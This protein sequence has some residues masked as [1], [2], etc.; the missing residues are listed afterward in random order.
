MKYLFITGM[1][2]SGTT[3][4]SHLLSSVPDATVRHEYIPHQEGV[5]RR[6][7]VIASW[8]LGSAYAVPYLQR[9]RKD[10]ERAFSTEWFVDVDASLRHSVP[11]LKEVFPEA[12]I[13]HLIRDPRKVVRSIYTRRVDSLIHQIPR[14]REEVEWW[15]DSSKLA[16]ICRDWT[17]T[18]ENLLEEG[19]PV[20]CLE[21]LVSDFGYVEDRL[22]RP[23]GFRLSQSVWDDIRNTRVNKTR[24]KL[25][26]YVYAK[27]KGKSYVREQLPS[28]EHWT[29]EQKETLI[30]ICGPT[31]EKCGYNLVG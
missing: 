20:L 6:E 30:N 15:L 21:N 3:F 2:R 11:A 4:T 8:F 27:L 5:T 22:L 14:T 26:R 24:G 23:S 25:F 19:L 13:L 29:N 12:V 16:Q 17:V 31:A 10:I 1:G 18:T 28:F 7:Y 9:K